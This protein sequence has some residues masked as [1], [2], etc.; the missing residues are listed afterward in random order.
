MVNSQNDPL[1]GKLIGRYYDKNG[2]P[3]AEYEKFEA[4]VK[5]AENEQYKEEEKM[6]MFPP[7]NVEWKVDVGTRVWCTQQRCFAILT[8]KLLFPYKKDFVL[9]LIDD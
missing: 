8:R 7:C 2:N 1:L 4:R 3:K 9:M 5:L 6:K